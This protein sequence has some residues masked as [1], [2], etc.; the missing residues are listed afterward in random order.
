MKILGRWNWY[1]PAPMARF[2]DRYGVREGDAVVTSA[3][4]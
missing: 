4:P 3:A 2:W 1:A